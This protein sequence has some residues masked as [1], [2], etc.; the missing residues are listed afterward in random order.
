MLAAVALG[1]LMAT[2]TIAAPAP[3]VLGIAAASTL[4]AFIGAAL[5]NRVGFR[6]SL[7]RM[8]DVVALGALGGVISTAIGAAAAIAALLASGT[9]P[10]GQA[11]A[12]WRIGW[13]GDMGGV[14][15]VGTSVFVLAERRL[16]RTNWRSVA[17]PVLGCGALAASTALVLG[18]N[19]PFF[20]VVFPV[21]FLLALLYR[22]RGAVTG[23]LMI[24]ALAVWFTAHGHGPFIVGSHDINLSRA[25]MFVSVGTLAALLVA[26]ARSERLVAEAAV[27]RL[28]ESERALAEAQRL[29]RIGSFE[30]DILADRT[31][32]SQELFH[33]FGVKGRHRLAS[34]KTW[35]ELIHEDDRAMVEATIQ[36]AQRTCEAYSFVHRIVRP[37]GHLRTVECH[38]TVEVDSGGKPIRIAGTAKGKIRAVRTRHPFC[39]GRARRA[40]VRRRIHP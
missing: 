3:A 8:R 37:D 29:A 27:R 23:G 7:E 35:M 13:L 30:W 18:H 5:L 34:Y 4:E 38:G 15:L 1:S 24:A 9:L 2:V 28:A 16:P 32:W 25:A 6:R 10:F 33:I 14:L 12:A 39:F 11:F 36:H 26:A 20:Y 17:L 22:Q 21:L 31:T 19:G 40:R